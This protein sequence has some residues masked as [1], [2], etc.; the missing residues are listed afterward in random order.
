MTLIKLLICFYLF[1]IRRGF[2]DF[3]EREHRSNT[4]L[5]DGYLFNTEEFD[6]LH[7]V[8]VQR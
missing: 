2:L 7:A 6:A 4:G 1:L 5:C 3:Y 8:V